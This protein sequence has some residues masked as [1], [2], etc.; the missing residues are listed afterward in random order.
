[1]PDRTQGYFAVTQPSTHHLLLQRCTGTSKQ[2]ERGQ[3]VSPRS[4]YKGSSGGVAATKQEGKPS[5]E[6][7][8]CPREPRLRDTGSAV[9]GEVTAGCLCEPGWEEAFGRGSEAR[10]GSQAGTAVSLVVS[11]KERLGRPSSYK[12]RAKWKATEGTQQPAH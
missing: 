1:M 10:N 11:S 5:T 6:H 9:G 3:T 8:A 7:A 4:I 12:R 2:T